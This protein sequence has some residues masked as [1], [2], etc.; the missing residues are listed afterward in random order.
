MKVNGSRTSKIESIISNVEVVCMCLP[1]KNKTKEK[2][3]TLQEGLHDLAKNI[4]V[5]Y[6]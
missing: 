1:T 3:A 2:K 6:Q 4:E 5:I